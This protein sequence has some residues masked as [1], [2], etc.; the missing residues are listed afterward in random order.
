MIN[1]RKRRNKILILIKLD[2]FLGDI[3]IITHFSIFIIIKYKLKNKI[4]N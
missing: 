3:Y 4:D 1:K 2:I